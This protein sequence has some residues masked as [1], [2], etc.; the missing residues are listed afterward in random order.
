[1]IMGA[2]QQVASKV[3]LEILH[4]QSF[5]LLDLVLLDMGCTFTFKVRCSWIIFY[6]MFS[7]E[8]H[9]TASRFK[10][11]VIVPDSFEMFWKTF[12]A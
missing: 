2:D 5:D 8:L 10:Y 7:M 11:D 9:C 12:D 4:L 3:W 6:H 1:M